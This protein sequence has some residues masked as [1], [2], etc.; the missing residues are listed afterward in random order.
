MIFGADIWVVIPCMGQA[1]GCFQDQ[2]VR[3]LKGRLPQWRLDKKWEYTSAE[4]ARTEARFEPMETYIR[5][6]KTTVVQY[7]AMQPI[8]EL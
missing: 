4:A 3:R 7:I 1:L 6:R 5:Q 2:V 8:M